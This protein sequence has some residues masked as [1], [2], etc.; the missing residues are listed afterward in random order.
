MQPK[1][2]SLL[3]LTIPAIVLLLAGCPIVIG[4]SDNT[5]DTD[6]KPGENAGP[7]LTDG[8]SYYEQ[9]IPNPVSPGD[10]FQALCMVANNG[11]QPSGPFDISVY[12]SS[13]STYGW[14]DHF[15]ARESYSSLDAGSSDVFIVIEPDDLIVFPDIP[16]GDYYVFFVIDSGDDVDESDE[17][18]NVGQCTNAELTVEPSGGVSGSIR[19]TQPTSSTVWTQGD[20]NV[21]VTWDTGSLGGT[22]NISLY[23]GSSSVATIASST[24]NDGSYTAWD[25]PAGQSSGSDYRVRVYYD[26][27]HYDYSDHF[28]IEANTG[29]ILVTQPTSSTVWTQGDQNVNVTWDSGS[30]GGTVDIA[31]YKGSSGVAQI[32]TS[33]SNDGSY[34]TW[35]VPSTVTPGTDY[36]VIV[37]HDVNDYD[38]SDYFAINAQSAELNVTLP[39]SST[40]WIPG[41]E[42]VTLNWDTGNLGGTVDIGLHRNSSIVALIATSTSNDGS[43]TTWDVPYTLSEG[44][45]YQVRVYHSSSDNDYSDNFLIDYGNTSNTAR[46]VDIISPTETFDSGEIYPGTDIDMFCFPAALGVSFTISTGGSLDTVLTLYDTD[47]VTIIDSD[48]DGGVGSLSLINWTNSARDDDYYIGVSSYGSNTGEYTLSI[49]RD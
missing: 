39:S 4:G 13:D 27:S 25:V 45:N 47:G 26:A 6:T 43:Y 18:N 10:Y 29:A 34:T 22:V 8:G 35:D 49:V 42:N 15:V 19:V 46:Y 32:A 9:L 31:L 17:S 12:L 48:D 21:A 36:R 37:Y 5:G 11:D 3:I 20:R 40:V 30:L 33:T 41:E 23:K 16:E 38:F 24:P 2:L 14:S 28:E 7:D 1:R 44:S